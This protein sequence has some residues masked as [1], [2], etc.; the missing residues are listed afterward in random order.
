MPMSFTSNV[1]RPMP[2]KLATATAVFGDTCHN[3]SAT[4][5]D[6]LVSAGKINEVLVSAH[7]VGSTE[8]ESVIAKSMMT[9]HQTQAYLHWANN[10]TD[11]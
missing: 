3:T 9:G 10:A 4:S 11:F 5:N 1:V 8:P 6:V 7:R 2:A